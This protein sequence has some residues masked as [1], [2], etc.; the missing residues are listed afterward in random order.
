MARYTGPKHSICRT[1][2]E[3]LWGKP[4]CPATKRG[5]PPGQHGPRARR[6]STE[7]RKQLLEKQKLRMYYGMGERQFRNTFQKALRAKGITGDQFVQLLERR[8]DSL[9]YRSGFAPTIWAA[10][11]LVGHGHV[12]VNNRPVNIPSY[13]VEPGDKLTVHPKSRE[14]PQVLGSLKEGG[15]HMTPYLEVRPEEF[16]SQLVAL[17]RREDIRVRADAQM[18]VEFYSR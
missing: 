1:V 11:Q 9:V 16:S 3:C 18:V 5:F 6:K 13:T 14:I 10:R 15:A 12:L 4:K 8:L 17:P 7:Y 2:G